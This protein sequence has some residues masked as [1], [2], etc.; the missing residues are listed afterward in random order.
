MDTK[1]RELITCHRMHH[2]IANIDNL[3][4]KRENGG[5]CITTMIG[6][7][8]YLETTTDWICYN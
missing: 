1:V 7:K 2:P 6:L 4:N 8:K 3:Y 5:W